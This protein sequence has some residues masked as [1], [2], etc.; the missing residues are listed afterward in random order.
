MFYRNLLH[1]AVL[2]ALAAAGN[3]AGLTPT[4]AA[5][6]AGSS[7]PQESTVDGVF[8]VH[9]GDGAPGSGLPGILINVALL[10]LFGVQHTIMARLAFKRWWTKFVPEF[11]ERSIFVLVASLILLL[12]NWQWR[13]WQACHLNWRRRSPTATS[14]A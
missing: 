7:P 3:H 2:V 5:T 10:G 12:M 8:E 4:L 14:N 9:W 1:F 11:I 6:G 13:P